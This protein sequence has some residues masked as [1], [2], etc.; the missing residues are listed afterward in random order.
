[1]TMERRLDREASGG[2]NGTIR[3]ERTPT[4]NR[5]QKAME[6]MARE[7]AA[8]LDGGLHSLW[9]YGSA[10]L[11]D[12]R[13]GWSDIDMLALAEKP[14]SEAQAGRLLDL[15]QRLAERF[16]EL[17]C[18][19]GFEGILVCLEEYRSGRISRLVYWGTSGQ[20]VTDRYA[21]DVFARYELAKHGRSVF[22]AAD[23]GLFPVPG[24][25]ELVE[26]VRA[27]YE[28]IRRCA[29]Q[30]D[31]SLYSCGW[32]LDIARC[33]YTLRYGDV[34]SKTRAGRWALEEG[35][36]PEEALRRTLE[37]R[38][39]PLAYKDRPQVR[40]WLRSLGPLVQQCADAL[41]A[42]LDREERT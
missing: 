23:R 18:F 14:L 21:P 8:C 6:I 3:S 36:L 28:G 27:H 22:G 15:R 30:T 40:A 16:P 38:E 5:M 4:E 2:E 19:R 11:D 32:I 12:Y 13:P 10:V 31:E 9:I 17:P 24:R 42:A 26:A 20:R 25:A 39:D 35:L 41:E 1:M 7:I 34:V 33:L 37:I 29:Q